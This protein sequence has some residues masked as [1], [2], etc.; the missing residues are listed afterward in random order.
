MEVISVLGVRAGF[1]ARKEV[2]RKYSW[3]RLYDGVIGPM[4]LEE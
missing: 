2:M 1:L 4:F 3:E